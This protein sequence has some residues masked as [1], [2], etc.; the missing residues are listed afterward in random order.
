MA[1]CMYIMKFISPQHLQTD[2]YPL[3]HEK[4][5]S[6]NSIQLHLHYHILTI[7]TGGY[8]SRGCQQT[9]NMFQCF[10]TY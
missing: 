5:T 10:L 3:L 8:V 9:L 4:H 2:C 6:Y 7:L 1:K